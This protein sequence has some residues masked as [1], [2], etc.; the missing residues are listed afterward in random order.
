MH[1]SADDARRMWQCPISRI[2]PEPTK[3]CRADDCPLWRWRVRLVS[4]PGVR[5]ALAM[6]AQAT[7]EAGATKPKAAA[8]VAKNPEA[9]GLGPQTGYCGLGGVVA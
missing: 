9:Y 8:L 6:A 3:N 7:G 5:E 4:D 2:H 1:L